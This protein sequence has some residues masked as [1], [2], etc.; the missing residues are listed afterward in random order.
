MSEI[1]EVPGQMALFGETQAPVEQ[2]A[3]PP[4]DYVQRPPGWVLVGTKQGSAGFHR[5]R[6]ASQNGSLLTVCGK[7]GR[8]VDDDSTTIVCC[9]LCLAD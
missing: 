7:L 1:F 9:P 2:A 8:K 5:V 4:V 3:D 6:T